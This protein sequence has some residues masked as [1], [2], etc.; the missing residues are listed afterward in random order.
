MNILNPYID[1]ASKIRQQSMTHEHVTS[2]AKLEKVIN[3]GITVL[4]VSNYSPAVPILP[5]DGWSRQYQDWE[6]E[7]DSGGN[8]VY[9]RDGQGN[10]KEVTIGGVTYKVPVL[11]KVTK[12]FSGGYSDF[13]KQDGQSSDLENMPQLP[14][15][16]HTHYI[17]TLPDLTSQKHINFL[18]SLW[19]DAGNG[20][21]DID[22]LDEYNLENNLSLTALNIRSMFPLWT[23]EEIL[24]NVRA[25]LMFPNKVF[26]TI[27]H[28]GYSG[29]EDK[30]IDAFL[31]LGSDLFKGIEIWNNTDTVSESEYN[32]SCYDRVLNKGYR[33]WCVSVND[34]GKTTRP[35]PVATMQNEGCNLVYVDSSYNS[36]TPSQKAE[37][38]L[39]AMIAGCF[40]AVGLG[41]IDLQNV[42]VTNKIQITFNVVPDRTVIDIDGVRTEGGANQTLTVTPTKS[43]KFVRFEAY[44]DDDFLFTQPFFIEDEVKKYNIPILSSV[45][46]E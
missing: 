12:T 43:N 22:G 30:Y 18:G 8:V 28:P 17:W 37:M 42:S 24:N 33:L 21:G 32:N 7:L 25:N 39:D 38:V 46:F 41:T 35:N 19:P 13:V 5:I 29:M 15:G 27:N 34:W 23:I 6:I 2:Q 9:E 4:G 44:K 16:E 31:S 40:S 3:R 10:I 26:G 11:N 20:I 45:L 36:K 1:I 14:N